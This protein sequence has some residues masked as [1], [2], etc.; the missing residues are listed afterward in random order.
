MKEAVVFV[1]GIYMFGLELAV[2]RQRLRRCGFDCYQFR[3]PSLKQT[4]KEN[5]SALNAFLQTIKAERIH[6][7]A[8]SLGGIVVSHLFADF[9]E[10]KPGRVLMMASPLKGSYLAGYMSRSQWL[11]G[12]LGKAVQQG[13][14]GDSP[15]WKGTQEIG[16]ISGTHGVGLGWFIMRGKLPRPHDG[17]VLLSETQVNEIQQN[18][19]VPYSHFGMLFRKIVA[20]ASC[21]FLRDGVFNEPQA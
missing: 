8:H 16:M 3:Y 4:P 11:R 21:R 10:Q 14:L 6:L 1:H 5:A 12:L 18:L 13:L 2:L 7:V 9:P 19:Q 20:E 15:S 17:T